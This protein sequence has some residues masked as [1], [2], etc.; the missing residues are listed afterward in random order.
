M[1]DGAFLP[2]VALLEGQTHLEED[3]Q[4]AQPEIESECDEDRYDNG[5]SPS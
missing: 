1:Q 5:G 2:E 3:L 4:E